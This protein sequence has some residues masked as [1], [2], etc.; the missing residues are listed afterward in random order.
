M[1]LEFYGLYDENI[2]QY[3]AGERKMLKTSFSIMRK[4]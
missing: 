4:F 2:A 3:Y 1:S